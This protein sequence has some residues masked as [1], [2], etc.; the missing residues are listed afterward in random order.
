MFYIFLGEYTTL[1]PV[2]VL[3]ES[4]SHTT[5]AAQLRVCVPELQTLSLC[6]LSAK[7]TGIRHRTHKKQKQKQN[8]DLQ[9]ENSFNTRQD[10]PTETT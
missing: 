3:S 9:R 7:I 4:R 6:L 10:C 2:F 5:L 8:P 1:I